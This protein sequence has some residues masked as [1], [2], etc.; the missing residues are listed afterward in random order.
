MK[1]LDYCL[2]L[3]CCYLDNEFNVENIE[4]KVKHSKN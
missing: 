2:I 3:F 1:E 4:S